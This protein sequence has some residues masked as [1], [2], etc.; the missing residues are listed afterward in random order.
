MGQ[1]L[2]INLLL[3]CAVLDMDSSPN[4]VL[5]LAGGGGVTRLVSYWHRGSSFKSRSH[6]H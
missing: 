1:I 6:C 3:S 2:S 4:L 5:F